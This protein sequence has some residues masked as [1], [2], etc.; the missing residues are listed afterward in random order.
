MNQ[1]VQVLASNG[2]CVSTGRQAGARGR[3][4]RTHDRFSPTTFTFPTRAG[5]VAAVY[6]TVIGTVKAGKW[7]VSPLLSVE[8]AAALQLQAG[9]GA[10][11]VVME[12][13]DLEADVPEPAL[14]Q[15]A[16]DVDPQSANL[17]TRASPQRKLV[18]TFGSIG[19]PSV[20]CSR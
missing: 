19:S 3:A 5:A 15:L 2:K 12:R 18:D 6:G 14:R 20:T 7:V 8:G 4:K 13:S 1:K 11:A 10:A 16:E 9:I 17:F